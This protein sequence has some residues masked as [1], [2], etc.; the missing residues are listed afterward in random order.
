MKLLTKYNRVNIIPAIIALL[1][2]GVFYYFFIRYQLINQLAVPCL[3]DTLLD[4]E[5]GCD[6][7]QTMSANLT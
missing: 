3:F 6:Q 4:A 7:H 2:S 5:I 1:V